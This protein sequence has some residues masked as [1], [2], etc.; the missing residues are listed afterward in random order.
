[1]TVDIVYNCFECGAHT[2]FDDSTLIGE[3]VFCNE[4]ASKEPCIKCKACGGYGF[5]RIQ[6]C[7]PFSGATCPECEGRGFITWCSG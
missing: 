3:E 4:C 1:V 5:E 6:S 7:D 2:T